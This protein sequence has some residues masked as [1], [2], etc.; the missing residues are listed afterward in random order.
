MFFEHE[1][2]WDIGTTNSRRADQETRNLFMDRLQSV[3][4]GIARKPLYSK[5]IFISRSPIHEVYRSLAEVLDDRYDRLQVRCGSSVL[6]FGK[7]A[8]V[9]VGNQPQIT[10]RDIASIW[11]PNNVGTPASIEMGNAL[12]YGV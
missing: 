10:A 11:A 4:C 8:G 6:S 3:I 7:D 2:D 9:L 12:L 1:V 5:A